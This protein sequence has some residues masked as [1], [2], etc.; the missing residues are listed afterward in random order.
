MSDPLST[1]KWCCI[2]FKIG[3]KEAGQ[4]GFGIFV[5]NSWDPPLFVV[6]H[7]ALDPGASNPQSETPLSL[8]SETGITC[9]PWCGR[10]LLKWYKRDLAKLARPDLQIS[11]R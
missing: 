2:S 5:N 4:R 1:V 8:V 10:V 6:Q 7:R 3:V 9:C 11:I